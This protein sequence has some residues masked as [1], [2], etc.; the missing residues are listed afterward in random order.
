MHDLIVCKEEN[1]DTKGKIIVL[2]PYMCTMGFSKRVKPSMPLVKLVL[3]ILL[4]HLGLLTK[5]YRILVA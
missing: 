2:M 5:L 4:E 3:L 1:E